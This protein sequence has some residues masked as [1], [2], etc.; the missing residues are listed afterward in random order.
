[1][2][3][4]CISDSDS[5]D[6]PIEHDSDSDLLIYICLF[7]L[8]MY[9]TLKF[10]LPVNRVFSMIYDSVSEVPFPLDP[11]TELNLAVIL[12]KYVLFMVIGSIVVKVGERIYY[13]FNDRDN[14]K[15]VINEKSSESSGGLRGTVMAGPLEEMGFRALGYNIFVTHLGLPIF[16]VM[17]LVNAVWASFH[18]QSIK[19]YLFTFSFGL[20]LT[21]FWYNGLE[22][23]YWVAI[24]M[25]SL[26]NLTIH[27]T[28]N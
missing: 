24:L 28:R 25:H 14:G 22:G 10:I 8:R 12:G 20:Y 17:M 6:G 5:D 4:F 9:F 16:P 15:D 21:T 7:G 19:Y 1:M 13:E 11:I 23:L 18:T 2:W 27:L 3:S 26:H